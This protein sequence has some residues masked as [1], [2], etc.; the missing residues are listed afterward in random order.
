MDLGY[1]LPADAIPGQARVAIGMAGRRRCCNDERWIAHHQVKAFI[2][3]RLKEAAL[4]QVDV[5]A[6]HVA[7]EPRELQAPL[8]DVSSADPLSMPSQMEGLNTAT[9]A[10]I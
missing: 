3:R 4:A 5:E 2:M 7:V 10:D 9:S 8:A 1:K 6:V